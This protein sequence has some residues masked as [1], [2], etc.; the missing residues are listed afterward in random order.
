MHLDE[1]SC[2]LAPAEFIEMRDGY[3][4][5]HSV[6]TTGAVLTSFPQPILGPIGDAFVGVQDRRAEEKQRLGHLRLGEGVEEGTDEN[7]DD[8]GEKALRVGGQ[9]AVNLEVGDERWAWQAHSA[10]VFVA[11]ILAEAVGQRRQKNVACS[12]SAKWHRRQ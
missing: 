2:L 1:F 5:S 3:T 7:D 4:V 8:N 11:E 9:R 6:E 10:G 12:R